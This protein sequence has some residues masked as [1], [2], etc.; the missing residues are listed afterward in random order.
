M[1]RRP[2]PGA[3]AARGKYGGR[4]LAP[5]GTRAAAPPPPSLEASGRAR[6]RYR[7]AERRVE[8]DEAANPSDVGLLGA[9]AQM[10]QPH[11]SANQIEEAW[12][13][14]AGH[15]QGRRATAALSP[16]GGGTCFH[17]PPPSGAREVG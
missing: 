13:G 12:W 8:Q 9:A 11:G 15:D 17:G 6:T 10:A 2:P 5:P 16:A 4:S 7:G 3:R 1:A 14:S